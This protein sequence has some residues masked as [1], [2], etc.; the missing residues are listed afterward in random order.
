MRKVLSLQVVA[1]RLPLLFQHTLWMTSGCI[2]SRLSSTS[3]VPT[4][5]MMI[6]LSPPAL[7]RTFLAVGCQERMPTRLEWP[8]SVMIGS[9]ML[10]MGV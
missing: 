3:P 9:V 4:F 10:R 2:S 7:S 8:S 1:S 6:I 5:Q